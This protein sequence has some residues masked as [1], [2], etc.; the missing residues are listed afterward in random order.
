MAVKDALGSLA[1]TLG[2]VGQPSSSSDSG[3]QSQSSAI[4]AGRQLANRIADAVNSKKGY[5]DDAGM[6]DT[7]H[8]KKHSK[9]HAKTCHKKHTHKKGVC[10]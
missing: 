7:I 1:G 8:M 3:K 2:N 9:K 4:A 6:S 5:T 10:K